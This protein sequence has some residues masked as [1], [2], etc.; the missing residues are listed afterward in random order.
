MQH[1]V[2]TWVKNAVDEAVSV[3]PETASVALRLPVIEDNSIPTAAT[4]GGA[5]YYNAEFMK[6]LSEPDRAFVMAHEVM[7]V[8]LLHF[9]RRKFRDIQRWN[10]AADHVINPMLTE[11][12]PL[13]AIAGIL[14]DENL[15]GK[16]AEEIYAELPPLKEMEKAMGGAGKGVGD[17]LPEA[18]KASAELSKALGQDSRALEKVASSVAG[19]EAGTALRYFSEKQARGVRRPQWPQL[20]ANNLRQNIGAVLPDRRFLGRSDAEGGPMWIENYD[21]SAKILFIIDTSGSVDDQMLN[22]FGAVVLQVLE[23]T[24]CEA[25]VIMADSAIHS[26]TDIQGGDTLPPTLGRGGTDFAPALEWLAQQPFGSY[27]AA[28]Y[29]TDCQ[30]SFGETRPACPFTW[31]VWPGSGARPPDDSW[32]SVILMN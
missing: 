13:P 11:R 32:G 24:Q 10:I 25:T 31:I 15:L 29:F 18:R 17:V 8:V 7:H 6:G 3:W 28:Y 16:S 26:I 19:T 20:V 1:N 22:Q 23:E 30:G 27:T 21:A 9:E 4:D 5:I 12:M 14:Y 2:P